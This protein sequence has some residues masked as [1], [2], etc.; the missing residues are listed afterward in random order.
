MKTGRPRLLETG[1]VGSAI[2]ASVCCLGP[3]LVAVLG[4]GGGALFVKFAPYRPLFASMTVLFLGGAFYL[5]YRRSPSEEC[6]PGSAC[7]TLGDEEPACGSRPLS[8]LY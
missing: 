6:E 7:A 3:L 5:A 2:G 8:S 4:L 1:A